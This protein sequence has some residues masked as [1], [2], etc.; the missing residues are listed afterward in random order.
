MQIV[1][2]VAAF[3][4][5]VKQKIVGALVPIITVIVLFAATPQ[6]DIQSQ[7]ML[8]NKPSFSAEATIAI[9]DESIADVYFQ[10]LEDGMISVHA[11][12]YGTTTITVVVGGETV[13]YT[14]EVYN[15]GGVAQFGIT[16]AG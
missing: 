3:F 14:L 1:L 7:K 5:V 2:Y 15:E 9:D 11:H 6:V 16:P 4:P 13:Q 12:A 8:P 10:Y